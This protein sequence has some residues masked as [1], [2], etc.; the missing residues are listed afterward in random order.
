MDLSQNLITSAFGQ[1][2]PTDKHLVSVY[3]F[4]DMS[5]TQTNKQKDRL[6]T[7]LTQKSKF[8]PGSGKK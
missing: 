5:Q 2:L 3:Y 7:E 1:A 8:Y 4:R 6:P